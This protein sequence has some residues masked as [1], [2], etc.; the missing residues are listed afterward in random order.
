MST[1]TLNL[2]ETNLSAGPNQQY[3]DLGLK[4]FKG[5]YTAT[6]TM[7]ELYN[8]WLPSFNLN[9]LAAIVGALYGDTYWARTKMDKT[10]LAANLQAALGFL[11]ADC[12]KAANFAFSSWYGLQV[13][14][15]F[16]DSGNIPRS[17]NVTNS[18]DVVINGKAPITVTQLLNSWNVYD[19]D[20]KPGLKNYAYGR[21]QSLNIQ[22][23]INNTVL[24][25]YYSDAGFNPP[26]SSW[27]RMFTFT[28]GEETS[29]LV[30]RTE[31]AIPL[32]E[33]ER[34]IAMHLV[35]WFQVPVTIAPSLSLVRNSLPTIL[36]PTAGTS[37]PSNGSQT[38]VEQDGIISTSSL[39]KKHP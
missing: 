24:R 31:G 8:E 9:L 10:L 30:G 19:W 37:I 13:R 7:Q 39:L 28:G 33:V 21:A 29:P 35:S 5:G 34:R 38:M 18:P 26:P 22:V 6:Q 4:C 32:S 3:S 27:V 25:M 16:S 15:N 14:S 20:P 2:N 11:P 17:G 1:A 36:H 12:Q 23:P